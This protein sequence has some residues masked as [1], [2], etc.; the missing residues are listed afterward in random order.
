MASLKKRGEN[1]YLQWYLPGKKQKRRNLHTDSFQIAKEKL[2]RFESAQARGEDVSLPTQTPI[3]EIVTAYVQHVRTVKPPKSAQTDV[4]YLRDI[5]GPI[6]GAL[7]ITSREISAKVKKRPP[8]VGQDR[9]REQ[10]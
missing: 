9:R 3:D 6:C 2:R 4:Y 10:L 5:F 8:K 7:E 1:Y